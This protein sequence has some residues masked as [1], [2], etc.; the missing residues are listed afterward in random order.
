MLFEHDLAFWSSYDTWCQLR[1]AC[2]FKYHR[3]KFPVYSTPLRR[4]K[5]MRKHSNFAEHCSEPG[6]SV[7]HLFPY[8]QALGTSRMRSI[9]PFSTSCLC[10]YGAKSATKCTRFLFGIMA[11]SPYLDHSSGCGFGK[12]PDSRFQMRHLGFPRCGDKSVWSRHRSCH[13]PRTV[14][15]FFY[16]ILCRRCSRHDEHAMPAKRTF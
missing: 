15:F 1:K 6:P 10:R 7:L 2:L 13:S 4:P 8:V 11:V 5:K 16:A 12:T 3:P 9:S 14:P